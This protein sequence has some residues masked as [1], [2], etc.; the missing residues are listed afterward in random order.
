MYGGGDP[1]PYPPSIKDYSFH[2]A[3]IVQQALLDIF[4]NHPD[5]NPGVLV[6]VVAVEGFIISFPV[7]EFDIDRRITALHQE[8]VQNQSA[9]A[10]VAV[11]K[12]MDAL[13]FQMEKRRC[14]DRMQ[15]LIC[16]FFYQLFDHFSNQV[17]FRRRVVCTQNANRDAPVDAAIFWP[18]H[19]DKGVNLFDDCFRERNFVFDQVLYIKESIFV[20]D[21]FK[22]VFE[23]LKESGDSGIKA[24]ISAF[25]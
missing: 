15:F 3:E 4:R 6:E 8:Q 16:R 7:G 12:R 19:Q 22:V 21:C 25:F 24:R 9:G 5:H 10:A 17:R 18:V 20:A 23:R 1:V 13:K 2:D 11:H 14:L